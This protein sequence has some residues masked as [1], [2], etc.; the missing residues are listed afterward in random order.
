MI[1]NYICNLLKKKKKRNLT[2]Y[3]IPEQKNKKRMEKISTKIG[4]K[5]WHHLKTELRLSRCL[6]IPDKFTECLLCQF[7]Q[8][9]P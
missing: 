6:F 7:F 3:F 5:H 9:N 1:C 4:S 8:I 2:L